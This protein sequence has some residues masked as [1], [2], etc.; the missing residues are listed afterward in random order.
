MNHNLL[1]KKIALSTMLLSVAAVPAFANAAEVQKKDLSGATPVTITKA[2][3][4]RPGNAIF[5]SVFPNLPELA[6]TYAPDTE[7]DWKDTLA[8]YEKITGIKII[9]PTTLT[10]AISVTGK[11]D[12]LAETLPMGTVAAGEAGINSTALTIVSI[13]DLPADLEMVEAVEA[14]KAMDVIGA[15]DAVT[16]DAVKGTAAVKVGLNAT[17][18]AVYTLSS[19]DTAFLDAQS[20]LLKAVEAKNSA[21]IKES[22]A[23]LLKE[24]KQLITKLEAAK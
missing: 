13:E 23:G 8:K 20:G 3:A 4:A 22:L 16:V 14:V 10:R 1:L 2:A 15:V 21:A 9:N 24:Y 7:Q 5:V 17:S 12:H 19:E 18:A 11:I 6:K